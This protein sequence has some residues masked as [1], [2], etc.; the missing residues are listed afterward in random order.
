MFKRLDFRVN[1]SK[2]QIPIFS[3]QLEKAREATDLANARAAYA[4]IVTASLTDG[5]KPTDTATV[6][7]N[8]TT[9]DG[10]STYTAVVKLT[11]KT[12]GWTT[13]DAEK[14]VASIQSNGSPTAGGT[15]TIT[16]AG[17]GTVTV[18]YK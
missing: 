13:A 8:K 6:T 1:I 4:E 18:E 5:D 12:P 10:K 14:S 16:V 11:Q 17:N 2:F 7:Y 3:S 15:C 9:A